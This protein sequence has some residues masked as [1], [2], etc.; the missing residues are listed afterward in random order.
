M[1]PNPVNDAQDKFGPGALHEA[2]LSAA[3]G[4]MRGA[5]VL[6][7]APPYENLHGRSLWFLVTYW[8]ARLKLSSPKKLNWRRK[9]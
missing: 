4:L 5:T 7:A 3:T 2:F 1:K 8:N 6:A 9:S